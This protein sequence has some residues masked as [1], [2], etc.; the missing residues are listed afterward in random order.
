MGSIRVSHDVPFRKCRSVRAMANITTNAGSRVMA[1]VPVHN[2]KADTSVD[3]ICTVPIL[4]YC[5]LGQQVA[6]S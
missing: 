5:S 4:P 6:N 3:K 2:S 1:W